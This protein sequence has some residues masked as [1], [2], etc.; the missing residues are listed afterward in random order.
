MIVLID[1]EKVK[2][3][4][5]VLLD[6]RKKRNENGDL[7]ISRFSNYK[8][9]DSLGIPKY[10][11]RQQGDT[12]ENEIAKMEGSIKNNELLNLE[13][14]GISNKEF[15]YG[16]YSNSLI[17]MIHEDVFKQY[18]K[19][20]NPNW[21]F[22][23]FNGNEDAR[24]EAIKHFTDSPYNYFDLGDGMKEMDALYAQV[25]FFVYCFIII[26]TLISIINIF[27]TISTNLLLRRKEFSTLKA[28]GMTEKQLRKSVLLEGTL[29]GV[30]AALVGGIVSG[31][32]LKLL[33]S[34]G[35]GRADVQYNFDMIAFA[36][37]IICAVAVTYL[38]T[39][40]P[41]RKLKK[42]TIVEG[43]SEEE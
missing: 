35:G 37:S 23:K 20:I 15:I 38:A 9:G 33:I 19:R 31:I 16:D 28:I 24:L 41:L 40:I 42:L 18:F 21:I 12:K 25:E 22:Y 43:I 17:L 14:V 30:I 11:N 39:A 32:L 6:G 2:K 27:N 1:L 3:D 10:Q 13:V 4:G 36:G 7:E 5:V 34:I 26:I 29:Y 8:V